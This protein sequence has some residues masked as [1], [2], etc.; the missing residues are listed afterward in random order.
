MTEISVRET[1]IGS[2]ILFVN[3][4]AQLCAPPGSLCCLCCLLFKT[5]FPVVSIPAEDLKREDLPWQKEARKGLGTEVSKGSKDG[6]LSLLRGRDRAQHAEAC[7]G[8]A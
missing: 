7:L 1:K 6:G 5:K 2:G 8:L 4:L 3:H